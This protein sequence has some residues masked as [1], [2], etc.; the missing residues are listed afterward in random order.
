MFFVRE[1]LQFNE[2]DDHRIVCSI[3]MEIMSSC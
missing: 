3:T 2:V 1:L